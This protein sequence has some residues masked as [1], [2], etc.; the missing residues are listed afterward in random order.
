MKK[1]QK[2]KPKRITQS[3]WEFIKQH[4]MLYYMLFPGLL[5]TL[6][7]KY[8]P[9]YGILLAFKDYN[10][11]AWDHGKRMG[12]SGKFRTVHRLTELLR[13]IG[14]YAQNQY[15]RTDLGILSTHPLGIIFEHL[16]STKW[17]KR[18]N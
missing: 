1:S 12:G 7:F 2:S 13:V 6:V 15:L 8:F 9:M 5:L 14:E 3:K 18:F 16:I 17:K 4:R 11:L 10:P